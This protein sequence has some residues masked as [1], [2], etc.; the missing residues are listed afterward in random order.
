MRT[1]KV[2]V[3]VCAA[4]F[5][6]SGASAFAQSSGTNPGFSVEAI[7]RTID[8]C[9]DFYQ[10]ACGN[11]L[12]KTEIPADQTEWISFTELYERNLVTLRGILEKAAAGGASRSAIEQKIGDYYGACMDEKAA[13]AKGLDPLK[14]E[15]DRVAA[16]T[17]KAALIDVIAHSHVIGA[18]S[19]FGFYSSPDLHNAD[20]V[21]AYIDQG[22]LTLPDRNYYIKDEQ[23]MVEM[24]KTLTDYA[25]ALFTLSGQSAQQAADS[26]QTV[27]R[28]ET[29]LAKASM[30]RTERRDPK[31][32]DHKMTRDAAVAL[33]PNFYLQRYFSD[34][35]T[36]SFSD[37]N[38]VNPD[39]FKSVNALVQSESLDALKTYINFHVLN[40]GSPWLSKPYVDANFKFQQA[41]T[42][43]D[44]IKPRW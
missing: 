35:N 10:Y 41:L 20:M 13:E 26:A 32:R 17:D 15:L 43:Q 2:L 39:F 37:M 40:A 12:K 14:P 3:A 4:G 22:G 34:V 28:I 16:A 21:I 42:G 7:D 8:P 5:A 6:L 44:E 27:L 36:P 38:V 19:L 11:W 31:K 1:A 23:K 9:A 25:T 29:A 18:N 33:A 30:D 24:R